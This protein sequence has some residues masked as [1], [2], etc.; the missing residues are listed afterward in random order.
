MGSI[1]VREFTG[2]LDTRRLPETTP[3]GTLLTARNGHITRGG[4]FEQRAAIQ[5]A[6]DLPPNTFGLAYQQG[7]LFIFAETDPGGALDSDIGFFEIKHPDGI[8]N[9]ARVLSW[10]LFAGNSSRQVTPGA[11][12][13]M[14][15]T[16]AVGTPQR[17]GVSSGSSSGCA[18]LR[19][20]DET[21]Q[22]WLTGRAPTAGSLGSPG[23]QYETIG[24]VSL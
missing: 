8:T 7:A 23:A 2:G 9:P 17:G 16:N 20:K 6:Y 10:D 13:P 3:G 15:R 19:E 21:R 12:G 5:K 24:W 22:V 11:R 4:E 18:D 1:W 14:S